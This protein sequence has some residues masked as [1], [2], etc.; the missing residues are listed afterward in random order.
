MRTGR[1]ILKERLG[2]KCFDDDGEQVGHFWSILDTRPY[3]RVMQA[4]VR[5]YFEEKRYEKST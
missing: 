3:M 5:L 1:N 2:R 4:L